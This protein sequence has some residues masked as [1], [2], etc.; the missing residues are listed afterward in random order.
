MQT[1]T[2][3]QKSQT[4]PAPPGRCQTD[5]HCSR[6]TLDCVNQDCSSDKM[7]S[8]VSSSPKHHLSQTA[9]LAAT[10]GRVWVSKARVQLRSHSSPPGPLSCTCLALHLSHHTSQWCD[11]KTH[12]LSS[13]C[14]S[15]TEKQDTAAMSRADYKP[16]RGSGPSQTQALHLGPPWWRT[17]RA[18]TH[19]T[20]FHILVQ[21]HRQISH[22]K[23]HKT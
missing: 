12:T 3:V 18:F 21:R 16:L 1:L 6:W 10:S 4:A 19:E 13:H 7:C 8:F 23:T 20:A 2:N 22:T 17:P 15:K 11:T 9:G 5:L 14:D